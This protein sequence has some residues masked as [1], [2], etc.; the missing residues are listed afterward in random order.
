MRVRVKFLS[1]VFACG[2]NW[3]SLS[4]RAMLP[5]LK[6]PIALSLTR[7]R[8]FLLF[9]SCKNKKLFLTKEPPCVWGLILA[10]LK[11]ERV[12]LKIMEKRKFQNVIVI[13]MSSIMLLE[14]S[15]KIRDWLLVGQAPITP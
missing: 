11:K 9:T 12:L 8:L 1:M 3:L 7:I 15:L 2:C 10:S 14:N 4:L 13:V 6:E 5:V